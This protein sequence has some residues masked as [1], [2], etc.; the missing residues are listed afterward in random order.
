MPRRKKTDGSLRRVEFHS[1]WRHLDEACAGD[2][3]VG[4]VMDAA[5]RQSEKHSGYLTCKV[6]MDYTEGGKTAPFWPAGEEGP[7]AVAF[8]IQAE[9]GGHT[10]VADYLNKHLVY[11][12]LKIIAF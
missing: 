10:E 7:R 11:K 5:P 8:L 12:V 3:S 2:H 6:G 4:L 1:E 9:A